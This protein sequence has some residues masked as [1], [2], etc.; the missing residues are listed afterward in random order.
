MNKLSRLGWTAG[1]SLEAYGVRIGLRSN[2]A[3]SPSQL[4]RALPPGC[5]QTDQEIVEV[6]FSLRIGSRTNTRR[7]RNYHLL[8]NGFELRERTLDLDSLFETLERELLLTASL[9][10]KSHVF[11]HAGVVE[12]N[13][14]G[15]LLPGRS[16]TGKTTLVRALVD[17]GATYYSDEMAALDESGN[18][19]P[20]PRDLRVRHG[21]ST[22]RVSVADLGGS[23]G[24]QP[25][26]VR[27]ILACRHEPGANW[28]PRPLKPS[29]ALL[30]LFDNAVAARRDPE[31][32]LT[33][34]ERAIDGVAAFKGRRGDVEQVIDFLSRPESLFRQLAPGDSVPISRPVPLLSEEEIAI[35]A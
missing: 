33:V 17:A 11:I 28:R 18:I 13:G 1:L 8:Y 19:H 23:I 7:Q 31:R 21:E 32:V 3:L 5:T 6:L 22:E 2:A 25:I 16:G 35:H 29:R 15:I 30:E 9:L 4:V 20:F 27:A 12:W 14:S 10:S 34:L 26:P 24:H